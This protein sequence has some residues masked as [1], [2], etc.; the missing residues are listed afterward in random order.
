MTQ[1]HQVHDVF[2]AYGN[3]FMWAI[4]SYATNFA[5]LRN[6]I[7]VLLRAWGYSLIEQIG[8]VKSGV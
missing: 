3:L 8:I 2:K 1:R 6:I 5:V 4:E 7:C